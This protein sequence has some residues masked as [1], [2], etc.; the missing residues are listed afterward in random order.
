MTLTHFFSPSDLNSPSLLS[1]SLSLSLSLLFEF[2]LF[3]SS[4]SVIM[5]LLQLSLSKSRNENIATKRE[6]I[7]ERNQKRMNELEKERR[8]DFD[9]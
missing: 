2:S 8:G 5:L 7:K 9:G 4:L 6:E 3:S 1:P